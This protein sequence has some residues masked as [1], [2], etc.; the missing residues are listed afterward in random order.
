M[1]RKFAKEYGDLLDDESDEFES[2]RISV[3]HLSK[4]YARLEKL[5]ATSRALVGLP[6]MLILGLV[7]A[8]DLFLSNLVKAIFHARPELLSASAQNISLKE[9]F[10]IGSLV[11]WV[12]N[13]D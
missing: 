7:S 2:Y 12:A 10:E 6:S 11:S 1:L 9:L 5:D 4:F 3:A 13:I 8:Y